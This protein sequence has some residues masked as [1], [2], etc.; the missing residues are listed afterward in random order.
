MPINLIY[1]KGGKEHKKT[2]IDKQL[3]VDNFG[4]QRECFLNITRLWPYTFDKIKD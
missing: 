4:A 3:N 1:R 2:E